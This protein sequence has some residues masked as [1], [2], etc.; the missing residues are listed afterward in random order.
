MVK[1][2]Y[3]ED[4]LFGYTEISAEHNEIMWRYA[5]NYFMNIYHKEKKQMLIN[6]CFNG[7]IFM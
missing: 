5:F 3:P 4:K 2:G 7:I 6:G 1:C